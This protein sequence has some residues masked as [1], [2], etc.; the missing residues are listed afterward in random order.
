MVWSKLNTGG[1][2]YEEILCSRFLIGCYLKQDMLYASDSQPFYV[3]VPVYSKK[4]THVPLS[5]M[6]E[7][8]LWHFY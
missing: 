2:F 3:R 4:K 7:G 6:T 1:Q 8:I 5:K